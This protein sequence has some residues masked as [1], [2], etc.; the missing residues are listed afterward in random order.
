MI[1]TEAGRSASRDTRGR[2]IFT[3][4]AKMRAGFDPAARG[5]ERLGCNNFEPVQ[6]LELPVIKAARLGKLGFPV[7]PSK[8]TAATSLKVLPTVNLT[9]D[10]RGGVTRITLNVSPSGRVRQHGGRH[11]CQE[12]EYYDE[13][14]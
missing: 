5:I 7:D 4:G 10:G 14:P 9:S 3:L 11:A 1:R 8:S 12:R 2:T 6:K 13:L